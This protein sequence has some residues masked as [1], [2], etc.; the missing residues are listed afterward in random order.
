M[1]QSSAA[2]SPE[3][4]D[5]LEAAPGDDGD[6]ELKKKQDRGASPCHEEEVYCRRAR[7]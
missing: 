5:L 1:V 2:P 6:P 4:I 7:R 3:V